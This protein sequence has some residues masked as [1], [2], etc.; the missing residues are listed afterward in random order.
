MQLFFGTA[1]RALL[2]L[3]GVGAAG[4]VAGVKTSHL[5]TAVAG[6]AT[7]YYLTKKGA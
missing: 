3:F 5:L 2:T 7:V 1:T 6:G 4:Y